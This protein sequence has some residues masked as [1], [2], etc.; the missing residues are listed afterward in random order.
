MVEQ[1][2][3]GSI[4]CP[5]CRRLI[6]ANSSVCIHCGHKTR[7]RW[8]IK[9]RLGLPN[10]LPLD[11]TTVI[12]SVCIVLY[13]LALLIDLRAVL[14]VRGLFD[15]LSPSG[16]ALFGLG[17]TGAGIARLPGGWW[18]I[19][20]A[21]YLH[22]SLLHILFN[23]LW[24]R[25]LGPLVEE[26]YG[27]ARLVVIFTV[28]GVLGFVFS[29]LWGIQATVGASGSIFGLLAAVIYY[30]KRRGGV[31]GQDLVRRVGSWVLMFFIFGFLIPGV[32]NL[33]HAGGFI[34]GYLCAFLLGYE[35][36]E[37]QAQLSRLL[38]GAAVLLTIVAFVRIIVF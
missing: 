8:N 18:T 12:S 25:Q 29:N 31:W 4:L 16:E 22:G 1:Q 15:L 38:A 3:P 32:N 28:A 10:R 21:I 20:T 30:G 11:A 33:A 35:N 6:S 2:R 27:V 17:M 14:Q 26:L 37:R 5:S 19:F 7:S 9:Q 13:V 36:K 34:G 23:V 24:I